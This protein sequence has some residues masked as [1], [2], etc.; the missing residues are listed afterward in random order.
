MDKKT[1]AVIIVIA[2]IVLSV[3]VIVEH[4][5]YQALVL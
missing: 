3:N 2:I 4:P 1:I 5:V